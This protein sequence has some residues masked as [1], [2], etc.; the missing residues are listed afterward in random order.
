[1][2]EIL[3]LEKLFGNFANFHLKDKEEQW[4]KRNYMGFL[5]IALWDRDFRA[6]KG[7]KNGKRELRLGDSSVAIRE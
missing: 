2:R 6:S 1:M 5:A 7:R 3:G 4:T